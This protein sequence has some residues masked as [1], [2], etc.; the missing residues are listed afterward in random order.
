MTQEAAGNMSANKGCAMKPDSTKST[1]GTLYTLKA[2]VES[3][4]EEEKENEER[5]SAD[6]CMKV[7]NDVV[8]RGSKEYKTDS[9]L[10]KFRVLNYNIGDPR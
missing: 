7:R 2:V 9:E 8:G 5:H 1:E 6:D 4:T 10:E 3:K